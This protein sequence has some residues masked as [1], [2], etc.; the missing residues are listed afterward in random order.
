RLTSDKKDLF[1]CA[2]KEMLSSD[3][4][5]ARIGAAELLISLV[6]NQEDALE[7]LLNVRRDTRE[8][9]R[10]AYFLKRNGLLT[11]EMLPTFDQVYVTNRVDREFNLYNLAEL[12]LALQPGDPEALEILELL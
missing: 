11:L 2:L 9:A 1:K 3:D 8:W 6:T 4:V 7:V 12:R 10:V 5:E